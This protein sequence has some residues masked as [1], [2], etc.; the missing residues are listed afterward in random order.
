MLA[1]SVTGITPLILNIQLVVR[2][3]LYLKKK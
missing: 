3:H 2:W 1:E